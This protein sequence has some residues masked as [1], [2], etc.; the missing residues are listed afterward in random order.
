[1]DRASAT[2]VVALLVATFA[3]LTALFAVFA[4]Q[5]QTPDAR[6][7]QTRADL[8]ASEGELLEHMALFQ[9]YAEKTDLAA[10]AGNWN[11]AAFY[12]DKIR[13]N[14]VLV[15]DGGYV[16]GGVDISEIA[17]TMALDRAEA[18]VAATEAA[19]PSV[20]EAAY[21]QMI[22]GCNNCHAR[23]GYGAIVIVEPDAAR[24]PSQRFAPLSGR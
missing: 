24:Y 23:S 11:L 2:S 8:R 1:M 3:V 22:D 13:D 14:A 20:Y 10:E 15:V 4:P 17:S 5:T 21:A 6:T 7:A 9:R 19:D 12:A 18:L 16:L